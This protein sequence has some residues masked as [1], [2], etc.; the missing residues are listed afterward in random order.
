MPRYVK[1]HTGTFKKRYKHLSKDQAQSFLTRLYPHE[2]SQVRTHAKLF[3]DRKLTHPTKI[4]PSSYDMLVNAKYPHHIVQEIE[5]QH[6]AHHDPLD[7]SH[8]GGGFLEALNAVGT[9]MYNTMTPLPWLY[10][11]LGWSAPKKEQTEQSKMEAALLREAYKDEGKRQNLVDGYQLLPQYSSDYTA[12]YKAPNGSLHVNIRGSKTKKDWLY[13]DALIVMRNRPGDKQTEDLQQFMID[14]ARENPDSDIV[15]NAHSLSG[16]FVQNAF[17][18]ATPE[19]AEWLDHYDRINL[20]NPG[21]S[22]FGDLGGIREFI[23]DPRVNLYLNKSDLISETYATEIPEGYDR[24]TWGE[25][26]INPLSAHTYEQ[27]TDQPE[28]PQEHKFEHAHNS[29]ADKFDFKPQIGP[30]PVQI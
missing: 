21:A 28:Q 1:N 29:I 16:S 30:I 25:T 2:F 8:M 6:R 13:H 14:V 12:V 7:E 24:V 3:M 5:K 23:S 15:V 18:S 9:Y 17:V 4:K 26:S 27:W 10:D 20:Y 19:E 11:K 22:P